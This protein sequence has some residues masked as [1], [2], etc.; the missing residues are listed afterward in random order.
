MRARSLLP[1]AEHCMISEVR[2][3]CCW[4]PQWSSEACNFPRLVTHSVYWDRFLKHAAEFFHLGLFGI[5]SE[6]YGRKFRC[7][8]FYYNLRLLVIKTTANFLVYPTCI[9]TF[10]K[11]D[12]RSISTMCITPW[13]FVWTKGNNIIHQQLFLTLFLTLFYHF[14]VKQTNN[15]TWCCKSLRKLFTTYQY[16]LYHL[17]IYERS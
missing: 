7:L 3:C 5:I 14:S 11:Y 12:S 2:L 15:H 6:R 17:Y 8:A 4:D 1:P 9:E 13:T 16:W 10:V